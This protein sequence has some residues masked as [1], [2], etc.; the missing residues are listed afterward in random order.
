MR[1]KTSWFSAAIFKSQVTR[2]TPIW[3]LYTL[4][5]VLAWPV[6]TALSLQNMI[7]YTVLEKFSTVAVHA[8]VPGS[9]FIIVVFSILVATY[10]FSYLYH[11]A[12]ANMMHA[13]PVKRRALFT[14]TYVAGLCFLVVPQTLAFVLELLVGTMNQVPCLGIWVRWYVI[15]LLV[16]LFF[17]SLATLCCM[18]A[19]HPIGAVA[20]Y[21][22]F[23]L[24]YDVVSFVM[25][26][27]ISSFCYG[28]SGGF[29]IFRSLL[30]GQGDAPGWGVLS[31]VRYLAANVMIVI[32]DGDA[33]SAYERLTDLQ[34]AVS[35]VHLMGLNVLLGY[36]FV[37]GLLAVLAWQ[38]YRIRRIE[39]AGDMVA[40]EVLRVPVRWFVT[41]VTGMCLA[42]VMLM[43]RFPTFIAGAPSMMMTY[44]GFFVVSACI[45]FVITEMIL[46]KSVHIFSK[47]RLLECA[48]LCFAGVLILSYIG[49]D[50]LGITR[51]VP[52]PEDVRVV[53]IDGS[54]PIVGEAGLDEVSDQ[55]IQEVCALHQTL[56]D[57]SDTIIS[58]IQEINENYGE[59]GGYTEQVSITYLLK[60]GSIIERS[61]EIPVTQDL[62]ADD[63]SAIA[64]L[65]TL[66]MNPDV[67]L[68][69]MFG[70]DR[71]DI[72]WTGG[73]L[74]MEMVGE[75]Y[76]LDATQAAQLM[77]ALEKDIRSETWRLSQLNYGPLFE[78]PDYTSYNSGMVLKGYCDGVAM[79]ND[80]ILQENDLEYRVDRG[81][82]YNLSE[83]TKLTSAGS[84]RTDLTIDF[85]L[86]S[87]YPHTVAALE[88]MGRKL[89]Y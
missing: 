60:D 89:V 52:K 7:G 16:T 4:V 39:S 42:F 47:K 69:S 38:L 67:V 58:Q 85:Y 10:L 9:I 61:Y 15:G 68:A 55:T 44:L 8:A 40:F 74:D 26:A 76:T 2:Y 54:Y 36:A 3:L 24:A 84:F 48:A 63:D 62:L 81:N 50:L 45:C 75:T 20:F 53:S 29:S 41:F 79:T 6:F 87:T 64:R 73:T 70:H 86:D 34:A 57:D 12:S 49:L 21:G 17:Y 25:S 88:S 43:V 31:P 27:F 71:E 83:E 32:G 13:F 66:E 28:M 82:H 78:D 33:S 22:V 80:R 5:L 1:S 77:Q 72:T 19:S 65:S 46:S 56:I 23:L 37:G 35:S 18:L 14:S 51:R 59:E 11:S 30:L